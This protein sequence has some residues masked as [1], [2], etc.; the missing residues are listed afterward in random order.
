MNPLYATCSNCFALRVALL[1]TL[2]LLLGFIYIDTA[3][4]QK[5]PRDLDK[6]SGSIQTTE[7]VPVEGAEVLLVAGGRIEFRNFGVFEVRKRNARNTRNPQTG[8]LMAIPERYFVNFKAGKDMDDRVR[9][10]GIKSVSEAIEE[11]IV[12]KRKE[13]DDK[14]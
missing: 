8:E 14:K 13:E 12:K 10:L 2:L 7:G 1:H 11:E 6:L 5:L 3:A 4:A 9:R